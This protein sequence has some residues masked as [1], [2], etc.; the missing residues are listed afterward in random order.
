M[1]MEWLDGRSLRHVLGAEGKLPMERAIAI[2]IQ[3]LSALDY[4]HGHGVVHRDLKPENIMLDD[5]D[6]AKI[7]D[8]GIAAKAG[9]RRLTFGK[10]SQVMGSPD[11]ISPEQ[12]KNQRGDARSDL[13]ATGIVLF[14]MLTGETPFHGSNPFAVM[15]ARLEQPPPQPSEINRDVLPQLEAIIL[16]AL[17]IDPD[18]RHTNAREFAD[19]LTNPSVVRLRD[20]R[21][22]PA[23]RQ[24]SLLS[25]LMLAL[26][27]AI[28]FALLLYV[29][30][31][32]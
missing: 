2:A 13:Y 30:R 21:R 9:S 20:L 22:Q 18:L 15:H 25:Y 10:L 3:I 7:F 23:P 6:R 17:E 1:A 11:Y 24:R 16:R 12:V 27:P 32:G 31:A 4:M 5:E 28:V 8:F 19:E 29:A 14:E 26:I